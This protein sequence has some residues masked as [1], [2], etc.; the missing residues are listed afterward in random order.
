MMNIVHTPV[1]LNEV[2]SFIPNSFDELISVDATLGEGGHSE[3]LAQKS[4]HLHSFERDAEI[5]KIAEKRLENFNNISYHNTTYDNIKTSLPEAHIGKVGFMLFDLGV[6]LYHFKEANR[7]FSFK[8]DTKLDMRLGI[9]DKSAYDVVNKYSQKELEDVFYKYGEM[10]NARF[11]AQAI[12]DA[13]SKTVIE[14]TKELENI[15]FHNTRKENRYNKTHPATLVFQAI[16]IEVNNE[17]NILEDALK[18]IYECL[19]DKGIVVFMSYHSLE[20]RAV[21]QYLKAN[22][23]TRNK[24]GLFRLINKHVLIPTDEEIKKNPPSRSCK[25][26]IVEKVV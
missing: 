17:I 26:R 9:N 14:T 3:V 21:K 15:I 2:I 23:K 11:M 24:D 20:D 4:N 19:A 13:R 12:V 16:R 25:M 7:G 1:M 6:S 18:G 8:D 22:E 10:K 5:L